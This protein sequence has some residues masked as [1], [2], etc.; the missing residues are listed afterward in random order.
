V[1]TPTR[2]FVLECSYYMDGIH[3]HSPSECGGKKKIAM[4]DAIRLRVD[5]KDHAYVPIDNGKE[6]RL[7]VLSESINED[8]TEQP[9]KQ[10]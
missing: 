3:V 7:S 5:D 8:G 9:A 1:K 2:V 6:Q 10:P 4:G